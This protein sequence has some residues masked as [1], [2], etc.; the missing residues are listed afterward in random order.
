[1]LPQKRR[2]KIVD[3]VSE[4]NGSSVATLAERFD[5]SKVT[6]RRDLQKLDEQGLIARSYGEA[7]P[8][9]GIAAETTYNKKQIQ[10]LEAKQTIATQAAALIQDDQV[11]LFDGGTTAQQV[12]KAAPGDCSI[13]PVTNSPVTAVELQRKYGEVKIS[14]GILRPKSMAFVGP[15]AEDFLERLTCNLLFLGTNGITLESGLTTP[16]EGEARLKELMI[17]NSK[18]VVLV[19]DQTKF[20]EES[21]ARFGQFSDIDRLI[22]DGAVPDAIRRAFVENGTEITDQLL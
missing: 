18:Y 17:Q 13:I 16:N 20:G 12:A 6:I 22:T 1:M 9:A 5:V 21:F 3:F 10:N 4:N 8:V 19:A 15:A 11:V 2:Q 7:L 14:G